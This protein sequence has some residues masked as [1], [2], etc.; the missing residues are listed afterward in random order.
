M[1]DESVINETI[2]EQRKGIKWNATVF[3]ALFHV[4][5]VAAL[6]MFNWRALLVSILLWWI[7]ASLGVG[8]GF[9]RLLTHRAYKT[10][11]LVEYFLTLCGTLTLEGGPIYWVVTHR[12][13]H[14]HT[15]APGDPHTPR[16]GGWWAH[17]GWILWG[18]GQQY[19][20][21]VVARYAPDMVKDRFHL[22]LNRL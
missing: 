15:D 8:M 9:H 13:H 17:V 12:I 22:W 18:T 20:S 2:L 16:D 10:P 11:K 1:S 19:D 3:I 14:A 7:S 6:F 5:A 21:S 4:S